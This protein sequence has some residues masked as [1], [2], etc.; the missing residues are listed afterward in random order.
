[1]TGGAEDG[2]D[3]D[4]SVVGCHTEV[5]LRKFLVDIPRSCLA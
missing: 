4:E 2:P 1:M 3:E 5:A